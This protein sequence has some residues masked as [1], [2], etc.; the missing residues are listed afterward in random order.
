MPINCHF[1]GNQKRSNKCNKAFAYN[2]KFKI[3]S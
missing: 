3:Q 1:Y 2:I